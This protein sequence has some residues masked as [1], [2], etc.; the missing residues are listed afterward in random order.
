MNTIWRRMRFCIRNFN[1]RLLAWF[2]LNIAIFCESAERLWLLLIIFQSSFGFWSLC[3]QFR[4]LFKLSYFFV[5]S[6]IYSIYRYIYRVYFIQCTGCNGCLWVEDLSTY[7]FY[8]HICQLFF[9][10]SADISVFVIFLEKIGFLKK[11][12]K[13]SPTVETALVFFFSI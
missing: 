9:C 11:I 5:F 4:S 3:D 7:P 12:G 8:P 10:R 1:E 13:Y 6:T 2:D